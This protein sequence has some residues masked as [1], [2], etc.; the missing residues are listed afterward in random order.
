MWR[1]EAAIATVWLESFL[2]IQ[3]YYLLLK[4]IKNKGTNC[5]EHNLCTLRA[6][7]I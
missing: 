3:L 5:F 1:F 7:Q 4:Y 2:P 6:H